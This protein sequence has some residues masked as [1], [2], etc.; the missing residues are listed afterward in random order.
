MPP[1]N[2]TLENQEEAGD[3]EDA[4]GE[5]GA[6]GKPSQEADVPI[7]EHGYEG[8]LDEQPPQP[9]PEPEDTFSITPDC[10]IVTHN[11]NWKSLHIPTNENMPVPVDYLDVMRTSRTDLDDQSEK[12]IDYYCLGETAEKE[13]SS[14][15][16]GSTVY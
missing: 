15:W 13:L 10:F 4:P 14:E 2:E 11:K 12:R 8:N 9:R 3:D 7:D 16:L 1:D 5:Q 6:Q